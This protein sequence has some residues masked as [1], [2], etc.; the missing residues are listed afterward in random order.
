MRMITPGEKTLLQNVFGAFTL[1][2][3]NL[4]VGQNGME[5]GG[6][7]NSVTPAGIP[8]MSPAYYKLD[9]TTPDVGEPDRA[10]FL[11][12]MTH[13]WQ[14]YHD[15]PKSVEFLALAAVNARDYG[16]SYPYSLDSFQNIYVYNIEQQASIVEDWWLVSHG[17]RPTENTGPR[18]SVADYQ[19]FI[20]QFRNAG[21]PNKTNELGLLITIFMT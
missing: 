6:A 16:K 3:D 4:W 7:T 10:L 1:P 20:D 15:V 17:L 11:H 14:Y 8:M 9:Y 18:Q 5:L 12:E 21:A 19:P 13:V 2:Y